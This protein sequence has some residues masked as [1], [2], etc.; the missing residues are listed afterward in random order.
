MG[1][2]MKKFGKKIPKLFVGRKY[3]LLAAAV[4]I[5][6]MKESAAVF[7]KFVHEMCQRLNL[8]AVA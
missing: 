6:S 4:T 5:L 2:V 3:D 1:E 7:T 8:S